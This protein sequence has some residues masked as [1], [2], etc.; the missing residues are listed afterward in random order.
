MKRR[1]N[2]KHNKPTEIGR[3]EL[4]MAEFAREKDTITTVAI[5]EEIF[6]FQIINSKY[7]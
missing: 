3:L 1:I 5:A 2:I 7:R 4:R 6:G